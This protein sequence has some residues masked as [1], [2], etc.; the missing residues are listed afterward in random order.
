MIQRFVGL[1]GVILS[2]AGSSVAWGAPAAGGPAMATVNGELITHE[3]LVQRLLAYHGK[4]SLEAMINRIL[5]NQEAKRQGVTVTDAELNARVALIKTNLGGAEAY[6][7]WLEQ[8]GLGEAQHREQVRATMLTEKIVQKTDPIKD[9]ELE[10]A[11]V[12]IIVLPSEADAKTTEKILK[13]GGDFIQLARERSTD[14]QTGE[15]GGLLP[16][17]MR[18]E[19]PDVWKAVE[20]LKPGQTTGLVKLGDDWTI[21]KL[22]LRRPA[23][24]QSEQEKERNR[25]RLLSL[26]LDRWLTAARAK[27]KIT[28]GTPLP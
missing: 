22:E 20:G 9:A 10:Q 24:Q 12:R 13:D 19:F 23:A 4:A 28:Y 21:L 2:L 25:T 26:K 16:P 7:H 27:A 14:R 15:Q 17:L 8:S 3:E 5:V 11:A 1:A 6:S 18:A